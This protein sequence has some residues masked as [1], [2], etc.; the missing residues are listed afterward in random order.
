M[1][2]DR[3]GLEV[4]VWPLCPSQG[5]L[6]FCLSY[7]C[8]MYMKDKRAP[9]LECPFLLNLMVLFMILHQDVSQITIHKFSVR[10]KI[11]RYLIEIGNGVCFFCLC[12]NIKNHGISE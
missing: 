2:F 11:M 7:W 10:T 6:L 4:V 1:G 5:Y 9:L 3:Q 12:V 8:N